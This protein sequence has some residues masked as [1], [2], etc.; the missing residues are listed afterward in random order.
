MIADYPLGA[1]GNGFSEGHGWRYLWGN[2]EVG[3]RAVHNGFITEMASWGIQGFV[4]FM[5]LLAVVWQALLK[6]RRFALEK[7][8]ATS[9]LVLACLGASLAAWMMSSV[10][11]DY[12]DDEW[13]FWTASLTFVY[14]RLMML[15]HAAASPV[16]AAAAHAAPHRVVVEAA[17]A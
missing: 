11:G 13:G 3:T 15:K 6:G 9:I 7:G 16:E 12:L 17:P 4:L 8:D 5:A 14:I 2:S 1:G 10:F